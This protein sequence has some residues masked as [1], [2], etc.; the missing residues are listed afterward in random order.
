MNSRINGWKS[1]IGLA[2]FTALFSIAMFLSPDMPI[3]AKNIIQ[4]TFLAV[5]IYALLEARSLKRK[6][7]GVLL[8]KMFTIHK[9]RNTS[10]PLLM[11]LTKKRIFKIS[12]S[13]NSMPIQESSY[14]NK[15]FGRG[16]FP[17]HLRK[18]WRLGYERDEYANI[19]YKIYTK[20][21][22]KKMFYTLPHL[23]NV[24]SGSL[25]VIESY[26]MYDEKRIKCL[27]ISDTN[28]GEPILTIDF[29][30]SKWGYLLRPFHGG[31]TKAA[32]THKINLKVE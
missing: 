20:Q 5:S 31:D 22:G 24:K 11:R 18:S 21:G 19:Q 14:T 30:H 10:V 8:E 16:F 12:W 25:F 23:G 29:N 32:F 1:F 26:I 6:S 17:H 7:D 27:H 4:Y 13:Y 3:V 15:I 9:G 2:A 28:Y